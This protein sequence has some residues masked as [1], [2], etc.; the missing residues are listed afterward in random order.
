MKIAILGSTGMAGHIMSKYLA[1]RGHN[2]TT[3]AR[4][5]ADIALDIEIPNRVDIALSSLVDYDFI[6]NCAGLLIHD[7]IMRPDRA[8]LINSWFPHFLEYKFKDKKTRIVHL[9]TDCVFDG[10][11]GFYREQDL[12]TEINAYGKSKSLG[13]LN[14]DKDITFRTSIIGPEIKLNGT[15]LLGWVLNNKNDEL[16]GY[17]DAWWNGITTLQ[18]AKCI[19]EYINDPKISGVYHLVSNYNLINKYELL[20]CINE[21]YQLGKKIIKSAGPKKI[22]KILVNTRA[23]FDF[24]IPDYKTQL[25]EMKTYM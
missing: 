22:N 16:T 8:A 10:A 19:A 13:E 3:L 20:I 23:D 9:S 21:V 7:S 6:I 2:I 5:N 24:V 15:G 18:L 17:E 14:N 11:V 12:H 4:N 1:A 25:T